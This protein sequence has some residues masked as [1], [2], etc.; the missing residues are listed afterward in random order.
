MAWLLFDEI[1]PVLSRFVPC[2]SPNDVTRT[3]RW[4]VALSNRRHTNDR[5]SKPARLNRL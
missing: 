2:F 3:K 4:F 5:G 1:A